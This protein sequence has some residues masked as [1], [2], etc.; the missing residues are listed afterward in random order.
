MRLRVQPSLTATG[1]VSITLTW[2]LKKGALYA[3]KSCAVAAPIFI[4][5]KISVHFAAGTENTSDARN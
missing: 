4:S 5:L 2:P 3:T 1:G